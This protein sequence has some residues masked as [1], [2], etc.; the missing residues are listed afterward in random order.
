MCESA[1][2]NTCSLGAGTAK[3]LTHAV[4]LVFN[5][6]LPASVVQGSRSKVTGVVSAQGEILELNQVRKP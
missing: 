3:L 6:G 4:D 2:S 1:A 5:Y